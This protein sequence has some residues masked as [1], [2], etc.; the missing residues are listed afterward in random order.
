[1]RHLK[2]YQCVLVHCERGFKRTVLAPLEP[3]GEISS[4]YRGNWF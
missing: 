1:M 4:W 2:K 3:D